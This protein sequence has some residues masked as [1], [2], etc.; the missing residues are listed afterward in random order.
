MVVF[1]NPLVDDRTRP[2][3][4]HLRTKDGNLILES[5]WVRSVATGLGKE[6]R[7][8]IGGDLGIENAVTGSLVVGISTPLVSIEA[9]EIY[10]LAR[11]CAAGK[12]VLQ[13]R[14][15]GRNIS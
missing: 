3:R 6:D 8:R 7:D 11:V 15:E 12:I 9:E 10:H 14:T 13:V 1:L 4:G 5:S 2:I